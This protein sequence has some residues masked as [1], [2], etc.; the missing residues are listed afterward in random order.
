MSFVTSELDRAA[1]AS[2]GVQNEDAKTNSGAC[3]WNIGFQRK[4]ISDK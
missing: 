4:G 2:A 1:P 3:K